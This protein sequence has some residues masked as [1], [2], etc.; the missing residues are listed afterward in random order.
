MTTSPFPT[1]AAVLLAAAAT[2]AHAGRP[3]AT[4]DAD[5]LDAG[6]CELEGFASRLDERFP[7]ASRGTTLQVGCGIGWDTQAAL[8]WSRAR[9][10]GESAHAWALGG[11]TALVRRS[12]DGIGLTLAWGL[13]A[14]RPPG[15]TLEHE[16]S[17]L[18]LVATREWSGGWLTHANLGWLRSESASASTTT[19]NLALERPVGG[20]VDLMAELYGDDRTRPW[21][22]VGARWA[23][24]ERLGL[25][26]SYAVQD[27]S[28]RPRLWTVG[29]KL[30]F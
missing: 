22:G 21:V 1:W 28:P 25:N 11:K 29:F 3:L 23:A 14:A 7:P 2:A 13:A 9:S 6:S 16:A 27:E 17:L 4:E 15:G 5:V 12:G 10:A 8:G 20:G 26:A 24:S 19:W 30:V 18:N